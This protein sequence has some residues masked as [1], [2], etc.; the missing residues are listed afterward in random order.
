MQ[1]IENRQS[2]R[3]SG[4]MATT[5]VLIVGAGPTGLT[6]GIEL[7]RQ[8]IPFRLIDKATA[9]AQRSQA[10]VVQARTLEQ[11]QRYGIAGQFVEA[12]R[13]IHR[14]T[15]FDRDEPIATIP[16]DRIPSEFNYVLFL[17]QSE[18]ERLLTGQLHSL[19]HEAERGIKLRAFHNSP[20]GVNAITFTGE[21]GP[22]EI[23]E[24]RWMIGADGARSTVRE[25]LDVPFT[26]DTVDL[27]FFLADLE[28]TGPKT[29]GDELRV[30]THHGH[31]VFISKL[32]EKLF[33]V[34]AVLDEA[35]DREPVLSD[36]QAAIDNTAG[37]GMTASAPVWMARFHV[38]QRKADNYRVESV[39]LA[40]DACHVHSPVAGQGMNT[41]MQD[42]ANLAW[43]IASVSR[44]ASRQLLD[45]YNE[46]RGGVGDALLGATSRGLAAAT[47]ANPIAERIRN[48]IMSLA[49]KI[50]QVQ[51]ALTG[52]ISET[53]INY[54]DSSIVVDAGGKGDLRAGDR[55]PNRTLPDGSKLFDKLRNPG[56]LTIKLE[57]N[58]Y[59]IRPDGYIGYRGPAPL[60]RFDD[61]DWLRAL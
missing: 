16:L 8:G 15:F 5:Q 30:H 25:Q 28:L 34:I 12:G 49:T 42:A 7:A 61:Y 26:G 31:V 56:H 45:T 6:M 52:F 32:S 51:T 53:A 44:G 2:A 48:G 29:P 46:E 22:G 24:A 27:S 55:M 39:F 43:K 3:Y 37:G 14:A 59:V 60:P 58:T 11:L 50:P 35:T 4:G 19:G 23:I 38:N 9:P 17:P 21:S 20:R 10:L 1:R 40:G 41:G 33:R 54:R 47:I 18:T 57:E 13:K 36:F